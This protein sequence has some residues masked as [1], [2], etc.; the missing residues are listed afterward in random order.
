MAT[1]EQEQ[2]ERQ[3]LQGLLD[4]LSELDPKRDL[5]RD[6]ALGDAHFRDGVPTFQRTLNLFGKLGASD[7][8]ALPH[9]A[10]KGIA[11]QADAVKK[12]FDEVKSF[13]LSQATRRARRKSRAM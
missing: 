4:E 7:L 12:Q 13:S 2:R 10:L 11:D 6:D 8:N 9:N 3:R 1:S 5:V